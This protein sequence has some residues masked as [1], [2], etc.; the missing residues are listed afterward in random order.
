MSFEGRTSYAPRHVYKWS[1]QNHTN[2]PVIQMNASFRF[3]GNAYQEIRNTYSSSIIKLLG[4]VAAANT[5]WSYGL[6]NPKNGP[7]H[8]SKWF[9][10]DS[11]G[12]V[13]ERW[14]M[15]YALGWASIRYYTKTSFTHTT[16]NVNNKYTMMEW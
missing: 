4:I 9:F 2:Q 12:T 8:I 10:V 6:E 5:N 15:P 11:N 16:G 7:N 14:A 13:N 1:S 3:I